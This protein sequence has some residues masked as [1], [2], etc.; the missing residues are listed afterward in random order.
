MRYLVSK[1]NHFGDRLFK[2]L[3]IV[4]KANYKLQQV[5]DFCIVFI[6]FVPVCYYQTQFEY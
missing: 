2:Y 1:N 5:E 4:L 3:P 6:S